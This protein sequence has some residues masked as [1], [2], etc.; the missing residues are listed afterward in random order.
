MSSED[1]DN[2]TMPTAI[3]MKRVGDVKIGSITVRGPGQAM[4]ATDTGR[5]R[6]G[7]VDV[8]MQVFERIRAQG[9]TNEQIDAV[10][11]EVDNRGIAYLQGALNKV[12]D[13]TQF[14]ANVY[15]LFPLFAPLF[16]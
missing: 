12:F 15:T 1:N 13:G 16:R 4:H 9:V 2:P 3:V 7:V 11:K 5:V 6:V 14:A 8:D 10:K